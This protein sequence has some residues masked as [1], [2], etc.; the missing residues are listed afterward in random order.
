M[1]AQ[2]R[3]FSRQALQQ[4]SENELWNAQE[5]R[6]PTHGQAMYNSIMEDYGSEQ[7]G[8]KVQ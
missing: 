5:I 2:E 8:K 1:L 6:M 3:I 4:S 7:C